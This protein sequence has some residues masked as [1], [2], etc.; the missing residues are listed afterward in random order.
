M[1]NANGKD[2]EA[3]LKT[4]DGTAYAEARQGCV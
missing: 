3:E 1:R 4:T 2:H